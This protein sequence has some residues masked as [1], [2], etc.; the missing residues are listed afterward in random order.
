[1]KASE[2]RIGNYYNENGVVTQVSPSTIEEL[3]FAERSWVQPIP[4]TE[5]WL[6][7]FGIKQYNVDTINDCGDISYDGELFYIYSGLGD[8]ESYGFAIK[9]QH[10]HQLQNLYFALTNEELVIKL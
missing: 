10:V 2:L 7:K 4:L 6:L 8:A 3:W 9:I 1:M 5:E